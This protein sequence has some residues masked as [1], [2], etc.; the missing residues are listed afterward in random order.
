[1]PDAGFIALRYVYALR[2]LRKQKNRVRGLPAPP[3][4][5]PCPG[6][7]SAERGGAADHAQLALLVAPVTHQPVPGDTQGNVGRQLARAVGFGA[8]LRQRPHTPHAA[9]FVGVEREGAATR[10][11]P[12]RPWP[13]S[14]TSPPQVTP[15]AM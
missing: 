1:M 13:L 3:V 11:W 9:G 5:P 10:N 8:E 7:R 2:G 15:K 4:C 12:F 6:F 14:P